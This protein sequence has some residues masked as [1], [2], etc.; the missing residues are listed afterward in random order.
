MLQ[1]LH[2]LVDRDVHEHGTLRGSLDGTGV[3]FEQCLLGV[4]LAGEGTIQVHRLVPRADVVELLQCGSGG[5]G[6]SDEGQNNDRNLRSV[7]VS[8]IFRG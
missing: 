1:G 3:A 4:V 2:D 6:V 7:H 5:Q 8:T